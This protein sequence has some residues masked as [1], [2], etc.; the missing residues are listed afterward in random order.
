MEKCVKIVDENLKKNTEKNQKSI[1]FS[2]IDP[3]K[4]CHFCH[5]IFSRN[6][7]LKRHIS[8]CKISK[9]TQ[10]IVKDP[11]GSKIVEKK[12]NFVCKFCFN[13]YQSH[14]GLS[15]H[16]RNCVIGEQKMTQQNLKMNELEKTFETRLLQKDLENKKN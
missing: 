9:M 12:N 1:L 6:D 4:K 2:T 8:V 5:K 3:Q 15:K 7:S 13:Q 11:K 10:N 16:V 14:R